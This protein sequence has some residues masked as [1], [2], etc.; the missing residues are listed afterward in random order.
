MSVQHLL[1]ARQLHVYLTASAQQ[2]HEAVFLLPHLTNEE[3]GGSPWPRRVVG[4]LGAPSLKRFC[5]FSSEEPQGGA[6]GGCE[7]RNVEVNLSQASNWSGHIGQKSFPRP[8]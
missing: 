8:E 7:T 5:S 4:A 1:Q 2:V 6:V 3:M